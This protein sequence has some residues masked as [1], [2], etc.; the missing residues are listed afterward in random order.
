MINDL[1]CKQDKFR[2][3]L[4]NIVKHNNLNIDEKNLWY[5]ALKSDTTYYC[6]DT[7]EKGV[8]LA[9][10]EIKP[11]GD[12]IEKCYD[13]INDFLKHCEAAK[14]IKRPR[15][16]LDEDADIVASTSSR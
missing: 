9:L 8:K 2:A 5:I 15:Q 16:D 14:S 13:D 1:V 3:D 10:Y 7:N 4:E 12:S 6:I 11:K